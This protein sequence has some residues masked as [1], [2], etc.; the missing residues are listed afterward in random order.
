[1]V[2]ASLTALPM[3]TDMSEKAHNEVMGVQTQLGF[4]EN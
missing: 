2:G 1:M 3:S 4:L